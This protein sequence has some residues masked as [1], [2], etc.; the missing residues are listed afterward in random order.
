MPLSTSTTTSTIDSSNM[1][2]VLASVN[3]SNPNMIACSSDSPI[4]G[5]GSLTAVKKSPPRIISQT[6]PGLTTERGP[7]CLK[8]GS[9]LLVDG[10]R[11]SKDL[12]HAQTEKIL[13]DVNKPSRSNTSQVE[14]SSNSPTFQSSPLKQQ[15]QNSPI[16]GQGSLTAVKKSPPRIISQTGPG[17]TTERGPSC[18]KTG[19]DF[20]V[21]GVKKSKDLKH[22]QTEKILERDLHPMGLMT[23][24]ISSKWMSA[25][26]AEV[27]P[28][29]LETSSNS[30]TFQSSPLKQQPQSSSIRAQ[31][32]CISSERK[33]TVNACPDTA[34]CVRNVHSDSTVVKAVK[35]GKQTAGATAA[36]EEHGKISNNTKASIRSILS[37]PKSPKP[38]GSKKLQTSM[39]KSIDDLR[40]LSPQMKH[41]HT[42]PKNDG[43]FLNTRRQSV[44][45]YLRVANNKP[46]LA[47]TPAKQS[48]NALKKNDKTPNTNSRL[49]RTDGLKS[50]CET[51]KLPTAQKVP[52]TV[53][54]R[55]YVMRKPNS[56]QTETFPV[57]GNFEDTMEGQPVKKNLHRGSLIPRPVRCNSASRVSIN[58]SV[59]NT[60][61]P[62]V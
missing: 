8:T 40:T 58:P 32:L 35:R 17:L 30:P 13:E 5:Q 15:P 24:L 38:H 6:G 3:S 29:K 16:R 54:D 33:S 52:N 57:N 46:T 62:D 11:K 1:E 55:L 10:V 53:A 12:K 56:V 18:L 61:L 9:E 28:V 41:T 14:T 45:P 49:S 44:Q 21:D 36:V 7:S 4:R 47:K 42:T 59:R 51:H 20:L 48:T 27:T 25:N 31:N 23:E 43:R 39:S 60:Q 2:E 50:P 26:R 22:A 34:S 37:S 19:G